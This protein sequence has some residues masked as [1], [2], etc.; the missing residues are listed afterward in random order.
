MEED[1]LAVRE[2][3]VSG[4]AKALNASVKELLVRGVPAQDILDR[5]MLQTMEEI[6]A[7]FKTGDVFIPEVLLSARAMNQ[8]LLVLEPHLAGGKR[9]AGSRVL[10]GTVSGDLHDIGKNMVVIML[11]GV[12]FEI[13]DVG[14]NVT[15][16]EFVREVREFEPEILGLSAL[17]T[18]TMPEMR[19]VIDAL[20][21]AGLRDRVKVLVGGAPVNQRFA[22]EIGADAYAPDAGASVEVAKRLAGLL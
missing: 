18:T 6:G 9:E 14:I 4:D 16:E 10:I 17:L 5:G 1:L 22:D 7:R 13:R 21:E 3:L 2:A 8:A 11:R 15:T 19:N 20:A 12:G